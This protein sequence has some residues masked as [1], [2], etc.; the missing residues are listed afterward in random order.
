MQGFYLI[1]MIENFVILGFWNVIQVRKV[2][3]LELLL[4]IM[5]A[6]QIVVQIAT[7]DIYLNKVQDLY[8]VFLLRNLRLVKVFREVSDVDF[9][10]TTCTY[11]SKPIVN[12]LF[13]I[14]IVYYEFAVLGSWMFG[15]ELTYEAFY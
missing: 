2:I 3:L 5:G 1:D 14:Y 9:V 15:G 6:T 4:Q 12:K 8:F 7:T 11:V 10:L 13:F